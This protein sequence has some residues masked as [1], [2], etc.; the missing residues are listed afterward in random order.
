MTITTILMI[1]LTLLIDWSH[2][3]GCVYRTSVD[4]ACQSAPHRPSIEESPPNCS[5]K[6]RQTAQLAL[7]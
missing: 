1:D 3:L 6:V 4:Q 7:I 2:S 5:V